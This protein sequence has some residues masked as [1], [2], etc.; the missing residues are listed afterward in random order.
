M[1][2]ALRG[3]KGVEATLNSSR[4]GKFYRSD[5]CPRKV[6]PGRNLEDELLLWKLQITLWSDHFESREVMGGGSGPVSA[7]MGKIF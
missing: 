3:Y 6:V 2:G 5:T 4:L 7:S 1:A